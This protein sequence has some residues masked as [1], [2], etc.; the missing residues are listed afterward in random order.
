MN[1]A[2]DSSAESVPDEEEV[3]EMHLRFE[4]LGPYRGAAGIRHRCRFNDEEARAAIDVL[5]NFLARKDVDA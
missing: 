2:N 3:H 1:V 5:Q 4:Y